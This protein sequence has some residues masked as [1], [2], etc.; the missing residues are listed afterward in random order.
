MIM[1]NSDLHNMAQQGAALNIGLTNDD[2]IPVLIICT[3]KGEL[4]IYGIAGEDKSLWADIIRQQLQDSHASAYAL[5]MEAW[6]SDFI[7]NLKRYERIRDMPPDDRYE[8]IQILV[9]EKNTG[10][11]GGSSAKIN[12]LT[13]RRTLGPWRNMTEFENLVTQPGSFIITEW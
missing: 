5:V 12:R 1:T 8:I 10:V 6:A 3:D 2:L 7:D 13:D 11:V 4:G 9:V